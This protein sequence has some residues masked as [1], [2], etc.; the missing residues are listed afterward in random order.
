MVPRWKIAAIGILAVGVTSL[1]STLTTAY[2]M[3]PPAPAAPSLDPEPVVD[4]EPRPPIVRVA[5]PRRH[6]APPARVSPA[7]S[8][9]HP[10]A[11]A[12]APA[13]R[14]P[15]GPVSDGGIVPAIAIPP[16]GVWTV[17][18]VGAALGS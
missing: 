10:G 15:V 4:P 6:A 14:T 13:H 5:P 8:P 1:A 9:D 18:V 3:R 11:I 12:P 7:V 2:L 17:Q 16:T